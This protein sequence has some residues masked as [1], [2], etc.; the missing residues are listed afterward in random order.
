MKG[1]PKLDAFHYIFL[2]RDVK[3]DGFAYALF[4]HAVSWILCLAAI[5]RILSRA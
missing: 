5:R 4:R 2:V 1:V 3:V